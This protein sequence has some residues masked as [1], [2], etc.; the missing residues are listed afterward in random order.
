[1]IWRWTVQQDERL[2]AWAERRFA[3]EVETNMEKI[4][5]GLRL[6]GRKQFEQTQDC[7]KPVRSDYGPAS[8]KY[9]LIKRIR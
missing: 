5:G 1:M 8:V 2:Y 7:K 3:T 9:N 6:L 4:K